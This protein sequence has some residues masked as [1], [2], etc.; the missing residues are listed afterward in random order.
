MSADAKRS[1]G[2]AGRRFNATATIAFPRVSAFLPDILDSIATHDMQVVASDGRHIVS[3][4]FGVATVEA[5]EGTL[6]LAVGTDEAEHL[7]RLKH[8][9]AGPIGFIARS[10]NL[11]LHWSGDI[12]GPS[13][14][15]DLRELRVVRT[16][17]VTP[18]VKR[19]VF[20]GRDLSRY[21]RPD[22]IH[23][24]LLFQPKGISDPQWPKLDDDGR[25]VWPESGTLSS[26]VYTIREIDA[27]TGLIT[28]DF[29]LHECPGP[30]TRWAIDARPGSMVG[31]LGPAGN[32]PRPADWYLL[33]GDE[34]GL[35]GIARILAG[36]PERARGVALVEVDRA[37][38]EQLLRR[39][40][41]VELRW[42]HRAG[43][44]PGTSTVLIEGVRA[45]TWPHDLASAFFWGGS[46]LQTF[47]AIHRH[48]REEV[49]LPRDRRVLYSHWHRGMSEEDIIAA[50]SEAYLP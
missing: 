45:C 38:D 40:A 8:A 14:P 18:R 4:P 2:S 3:S 22:Q 31:M 13:L 1:S 9:L 42:L 30:A 37:E 11:A 20:A 36:L 32:G 47:R 27:A 7:N 12:T 23:C 26:R 46:E 48:L 44:A 39:P 28:I 19:I 49:G 21:D 10:E 16:H 41:G 43:A 50:G 35:P 34:T 29:F 24:R 15:D 5:S 33:A 25:I 17:V 6:A